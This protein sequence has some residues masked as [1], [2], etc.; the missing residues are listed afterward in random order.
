MTARYLI[1]SRTTK[2]WFR[3]P[4]LG[5]TDDQAEAHRFTKAEAEAELARRYNFGCELEPMG[6]SPSEGVADA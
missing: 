2:E 3:A 1:Y 4:G 6:S 5:M